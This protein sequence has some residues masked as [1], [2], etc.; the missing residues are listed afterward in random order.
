MG[1]KE[2]SIRESTYNR[3]Q[4]HVRTFND[5][6]DTVLCRI[7][8]AV[9]GPGVSTVE[10]KPNGAKRWGFRKKSGHEESNPQEASFGRPHHHTESP[11]EVSGT[12]DLSGIEQNFDPRRLPDLRHT[13]VL[14]A[15]INGEEIPHPKW[16]F[17]LE[18]V[19]TI[20]ME[21][22][23]DF[24]KV[25]QI[26]PTSMVN[27][28]KTDEGYTHLPGI[29]ISVQGRSANGACRAVMEAAQEL[30]IPVEIGF[31]WRVRDGAAYPGKRGRT[32]V[33]SSSG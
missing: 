11:G 25:R 7:L 33:S 12:E 4:R 20:A 1:M 32:A 26:C 14:Y 27:R 8:D 19:V 16:N 13:K 22:F 2:I 10:G 30:D 9:D 29:G 17:L 5:T 24:E 18:R 6:H 31:A 15:R 23:S 21:R 3:L 28:P